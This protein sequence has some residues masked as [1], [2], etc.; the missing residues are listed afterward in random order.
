MGHSSALSQC[1]HQRWLVSPVMKKQMI[2]RL[3][4]GILSWQ[5]CRIV[6]RLIDDSLSDILQFWP[7][8]DW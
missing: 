1:C 2:L 8:E 3:L 5:P 6:D 4:D 7:L